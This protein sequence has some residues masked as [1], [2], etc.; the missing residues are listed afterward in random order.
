MAPPLPILLVATSNAGKF[1]EFAE[2]L[3][4][5]PVQLRSL[6]EIPE[7]PHIAEDGVS[8]AANALEKAETMARWTGCATLADDSGLEVDALDGAPGVRSARYAG[9]DRNSDANVDKLLRELRGVS[10][11]QREARFRCVLVVACP[12]GGRLTAA[13]TC[14]GYIAAERRG[15]GGFGY[16][17]VFVY[18]P[19]GLTFA[20]MPAS[21]KHRLSHRAAACA[22]LRGELIAFLQRHAAACA[23]CRLA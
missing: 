11:G 7:A 21:E 18:P 12:D 1:R 6:A 22:V 8:Y 23:A 9:D 5:L 19:S 4:E 10:S 3:G 16:D 20:Q 2:L 13:G 15:G 14:A 17:P